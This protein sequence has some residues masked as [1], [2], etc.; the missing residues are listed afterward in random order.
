MREFLEKVRIDGFYHLTKD[1]DENFLKL[2][3][4][5]KARH[6]IKES[7]NSFGRGKFELD[8]LGYNYL[9]GVNQDDKSITQNITIKGDN[10]Q[11]QSNQSEGNDITNKNTIK[12]HKI[13]KSN[14][15][16]HIWQIAISIGSALIVA[17]IVYRLG[18]NN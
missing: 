2:H 6:F 4:E 16:K 12:P 1:T 5:A 7:Q 14:L 17:Y 15:S 13:E 11:V 9:E 18:W 3:R 8:L 10:N